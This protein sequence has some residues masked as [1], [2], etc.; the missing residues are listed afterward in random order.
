MR[1]VLTGT[2]LA[3]HILPTPSWRI[4][5]TLT[6]Y[7]GLPRILWGNLNNLRA[8]NAAA[9]PSKQAE[10]A[11]GDVSAPGRRVIFKWKWIG[12]ILLSQRHGE[13][14]NR[15]TEAF[16]F[17]KNWWRQKFLSTGW[18]VVES[19][20]TGLFYSGNIVFGKVMPTGMRR[21]LAAVLG[22]STRVYVLKKANEG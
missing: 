9:A 17:R 19:F 20:P 6:H 7:I 5:T 4:W 12:S 15:I 22:S 1:R 3:I 21:K 18:Q 2:G 8:I 11:Q 16:Y 14:G 10:G 13:R